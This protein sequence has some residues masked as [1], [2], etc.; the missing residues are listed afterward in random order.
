[1]VYTPLS[2]REID[3]NLFP[4]SGNT[5][6]QFRFLLHY[7]LL[8]P[9]HYNAQPW[10]FKIN[11]CGID[12]FSDP[13]R[14]SHVAD[15]QQREVIISCG[16]AIHTLEIAAHFFGL[17]THVIYTINHQDNHLARIEMT[18]G[19]DPS[20]HEIQLFHAIKKR[21]TNRRW[22]IDTAIPGSLK[23]ECMRAA[24]KLDV[25]TTFTNDEV[26]RETFG[27]MTAQAVRTQHA[28]AWHRQEFSSWL[29]SKFTLKHD[30]MNHFGFFSINLPSPLIKL[31]LRITSL[32]RETGRFNQAKL[33]TGS[34]MLMAIST[35]E[36]NQ[37]GWL[38]TGR[39]LMNTLLNFTRNGLS[40]SFMNQAI[41]N[42]HMRNQVSTLFGGHEYPQLVLRI[43]IAPQVTWTAR[44][45]LDD[46]LL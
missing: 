31:L 21:Q 33:T 19:Y 37:H 11:S 29:R 32:G 5:S 27:R 46:T 2:P 28:H 45:N 43:G 1:M 30:G 20:V 9:S 17:K 26:I 7:A 6:H 25:A 39:T 24:K 14:C 44:R 12:V 22:F 23:E 40:A 16:A 13:S 15:P 10:R 18:E 41:Q 35:H 3:E 34:P 4:Y 42:P 8:A 38:N 36:D